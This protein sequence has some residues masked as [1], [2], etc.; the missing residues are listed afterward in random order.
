MLIRSSIKRIVVF[1]FLTTMAVSTVNN[2]Y[3]SDE[4]ETLL[5]ALALNYCRNSLSKDPKLQ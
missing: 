3:A 4:D 2:A 1:M 5:S